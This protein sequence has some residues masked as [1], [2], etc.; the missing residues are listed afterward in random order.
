MERTRLPRITD[1]TVVQRVL[2]SGRLDAALDVGIQAGPL[3]VG[4]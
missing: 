3:A 2:I 4:R 1:G